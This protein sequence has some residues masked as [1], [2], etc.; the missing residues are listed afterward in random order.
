VTTASLDWLII[1]GGIHGVHIAACLLAEAK[2]A[3]NQLRIVDPGSKLLE[4]WETCTA[5]TGMTHLRSPAVHHLDL[6]AWSLNR[7]AGKP[8]RQSLGLMKGKY[9]KPA[10][11]LFNSHC[12][13]VIHQYGLSKLHIQDRAVACSVGCEEVNVSFVSGNEVK[14]KNLVLAIGAA[15]QPHWPEWAPQ[16]HARVHH[17]FAPGF[18]GW[19]SSSE[20]VAVIGGGI[21]SAQVALRLARAGHEVHMV[22]RHA[23]REEN[24]DSDPGWLGPKNM[25]QFDKESNL[26]RRRRMIND[27]RHRGSMP[28]DVSS[29]LRRAIDHSQIQWHATAVEEVS[30][31]ET[32][33]RLQLKD[34]CAL[35]VDRILLAT[36]FSKKRPGGALVDDLIESASLPCA[37]CGYPV[38]DESLRWHSNIF[39]TGPLAE[40]EI[41]PVSRNIA[42]ARRAASRLVEVARKDKAGLQK[43]S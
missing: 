5:I 21:S 22:V 10:L 35:D 32:E 19:P 3:P 14:A 18:D 34:G 40:L 39:V 23:L 16:D 37:E 28:P 31:G 30:Q 1:G 41:G 38:V 15:E 42:G 24:F 9:R 13:K 43:A 17:I 11:S 29:A 20:A 2:I 26:N 27:A 33:L 8:K 12:E 36:G 6:D 7:F 4:R 25:V